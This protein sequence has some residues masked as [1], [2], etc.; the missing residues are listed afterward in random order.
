M[1]IPA[2][3]WGPD[4]SPHWQTLCAPSSL[5][6]TDALTCYCANA[7]ADAEGLNFSLAPGESW[8]SS[9]HPEADGGFCTGLAVFDPV[10]LYQP[11][12]ALS[13]S[14]MVPKYGSMDWMLVPSNMAAG[15]QQF[16]LVMMKCVIFLTLQCVVVLETLNC[17]STGFWEQLF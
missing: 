2:F 6:R 15:P 12:F 13:P 7:L 9:W 1:R 10:L 11:A 14:P 5:Q 3:S 8:G 4:L 16:Q 17:W